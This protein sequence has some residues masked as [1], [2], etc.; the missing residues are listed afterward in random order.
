MNASQ[1]LPF[2]TLAL[3]FTYLLTFLSMLK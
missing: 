3:H 1:N 2:L